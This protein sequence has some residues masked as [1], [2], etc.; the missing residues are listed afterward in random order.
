MLILYY[1][2]IKNKIKIG[3]SKSFINIKQNVRVVSNFTI[4]IVLNMTCHFFEKKKATL[5]HCQIKKTI[6]ERFGFDHF[7][8]KTLKIR[9]KSIII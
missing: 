8:L 3:D 4:T 9:Q 7:K 2:N 6:F 5:Y 1:G